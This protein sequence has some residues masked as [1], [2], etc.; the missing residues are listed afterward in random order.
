VFKQP[1]VL[2]VEADSSKIKRLDRLC[3]TLGGS[4]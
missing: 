3:K 1:N 2:F 4:Y